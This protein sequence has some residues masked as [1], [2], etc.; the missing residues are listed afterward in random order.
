MSDIILGKNTGLLEKIIS[1]EEQIK[2]LRLFGALFNLVKLKV[3]TRSI[4]HC[5]TNFNTNNVVQSEGQLLLLLNKK[6]C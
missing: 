5:L 2:S 3:H 1:V 4:I 6:K